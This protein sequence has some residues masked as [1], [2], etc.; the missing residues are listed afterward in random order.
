MNN[1]SKL[2][3]IEVASPCPAS[4]DE[5]IGDE[6]VRFCQQCKLQVYNLSQMTRAQAEEFVARRE[7]RTCVRFYRRTDGTVLTR[8]C[9][10]GLRALKRR[11]VRATA[12]TAGLLV[13]LIGGTALGSFFQ[14]LLP[15]SLQ[16]PSQ[17]FARWIDPAPPL[18]GAIACPPS[19]QPTPLYLDNPALG[20]PAETPLLS[21]TPEQLEQIQ[22]RLEK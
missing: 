18:M 16:T 12:A 17:A 5:M 7:G 8:D 15:T 2:D 14:R 20:D 10:V 11:F 22:H 9:P 19:P 3:L 6:R 1:L 13:A 21:P 4:W